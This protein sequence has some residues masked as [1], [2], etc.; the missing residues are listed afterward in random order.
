M[1]YFV[2]ISVDVPLEQEI[3][4]ADVPKEELPCGTTHVQVMLWISTFDWR[5]FPVL[6]V[7]VVQSKLL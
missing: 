3:D 7:V 4:G 2:I 1:L 5:H 6:F